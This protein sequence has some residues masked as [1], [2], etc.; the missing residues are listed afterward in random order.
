MANICT[1]EFLQTYHRYKEHET[2]RTRLCLAWSALQMADGETTNPGMAWYWVDQARKWASEAGVTLR[3]FGGP[4]W[5]ATQV[6][7]ATI[8]HTLD[9]LPQKGTE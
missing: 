3:G 6:A 4:T 7:K 5:P 2:R 8:V 9:N 1:K